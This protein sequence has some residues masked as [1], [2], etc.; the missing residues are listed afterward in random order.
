MQTERIKDLKLQEDFGKI[1]KMTDEQ[2]QTIGLD[3]FIRDELLRLMPIPDCDATCQKKVCWMWPGR[4]LSSAREGE[5]CGYRPIIHRKGP[6]LVTR[7]LGSLFE[8]R[9]LKKEDFVCHT[10]PEV[11]NQCCINPYHL[12]IGD[13]DINAKHRSAY[14]T[15]HENRNGS[16]TKPETRPRGFNNPKSK[17][18]GADGSLKIQIIRATYPCYSSRRGIITLLKRFTETSIDAVKGVLFKGRYPDVVDNPEAFVSWEEMQNTVAARGYA[19]KKRTYWPTDINHHETQ[20]P[21]S[22]K[23]IFYEIYHRLDEKRNG[24]RKI[25]AAAVAK[26][27]GIVLESV[28][29]VAY[30]DPAGFGAEPKGTLAEMEKVDLPSLDNFQ[31]I[32]GPSPTVK[33]PNE[34]QN[35]CLKT[36]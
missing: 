19:P 34:S 23:K 20:F 22:A 14:R 26:Y 13:A 10:C 17:F 12:L 1:K 25:F 36:N 5:I 24:D 29:T 21:N 11:E 35:E 16:R 31:A 18:K 2:L 4:H 32:F 27:F 6:I 9:E 15:L 3:S 8:N 7:I 28:R 30:S 33:T